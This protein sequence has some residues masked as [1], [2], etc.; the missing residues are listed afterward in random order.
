MGVSEPCPSG[1]QMLSP[2]WGSGRQS[3]QKLM[4]LFC[5]NML[6]CQGFKNDILTFAF[7]AY[8]LICNGT[9]INLEAEQ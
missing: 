1:V 9:K 6:F 5:E 3:P 7:T 2:W 8:S 4:T